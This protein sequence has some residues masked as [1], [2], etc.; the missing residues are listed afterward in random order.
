MS[1]AVDAV[2]A[3][4]IA[5]N[6]RSWTPSHHEL[7]LA[8]D[9]FTRRDAIPQRLL[10]GM[11]QSPSP[12]GWVTQHVLWLED[13]AHL[14]GELLTAWRAWLPDGH[15]IGLLGAYGGL[16]RTAAPLAARLGRD[17]SAEWQ[18]PPSKQDT[19]SWEDWHLPT[20]QRR[21]LDALTDRLVLIG[22]VMV[23][24]VNR[25]ETGH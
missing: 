20:E 13:V 15:M 16:A 6:D 25:G 2:D 3:A 1:H 14:A 7:T 19:S 18:A 12:Q 10:P 17:W 4:A 5:L 22:A 8:R 24:A 9:F 23:M 21:Q 11:P